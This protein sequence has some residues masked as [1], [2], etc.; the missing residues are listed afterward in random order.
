MAGI[1]ISFVS[2]VRDFLKGTKNIEGALD[3]VSDSL[4][5]VAKDAQRAGKTAGDKLGDGFKDAGKDA[6]KA[7]D[8]ISDDVK[9]AAKDVEKSSEKMEK[10]FKDT[11]DSVKK[12]SKKAGDDVGDNT[13]RG[14]DQSSDS[15]KEFKSEAS[16][17]FS[18]VASSFSGDMSQAADGVQGLMGGLAGSLAGPAGLAAGVLAGVGG[19]MLSSFTTN[20]EDTKVI[21]NDMYDDL[22]ASGAKY[23][24]DDFIQTNYWD[25]LKGDSKILNL[26]W[27]KQIAG[28]SVQTNETVA[29]AYAGNVEAMGVVTDGLT[30]KRKLFEDQLKDEDT[31][32]DAVA[33]SGIATID[34]MLA[35]G[36]DRMKQI[37]NITIATQQ[38]SDV[39]SNFGVTAANSASAAQAQFDGLGRK[40]AEIPGVK[41]LRVD[42][43]L[44]DAE[45]KIRSWTPPMV[46]IT[47]RVRPGY[48][49]P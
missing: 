46:T 19:A 10:S 37:N 35:K 27:L 18:E 25:I 47:P 1:N 22:L 7:V 13:K 5:D 39:L 44:S 14:M 34:T 49:N 48:M 40:I 30:A 32:N 31:T 17:N 6:S 38:G 33:K 4:D 26:A 43:D 41:N 24:S 42:V 45:R 29:L 28:W 11:F 36:D 20:A 9:D 23:L 15:V 12:D 8:K 16:Q 2:D 3:D 21:V